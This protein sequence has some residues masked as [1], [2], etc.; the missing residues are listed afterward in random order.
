MKFFNITTYNFKSLF[1]TSQRF[2]TTHLQKSTNYLINHLQMEQLSKL[3]ILLI[4]V[5]QSMLSFSQSQSFKTYTNPVI[6]GD[7]SDC[8]L[9]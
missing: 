5:T 8:T 1:T 2:K 9:T 4:L 6:P 7:H 3:G